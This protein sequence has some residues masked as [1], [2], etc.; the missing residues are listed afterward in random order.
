MGASGCLFNIVQKELT[1]K[2][3]EHCLLWDCT[4]LKIKVETKVMYLDNGIKK[5]FGASIK[6]IAFDGFWCNLGNQ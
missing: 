4:W 5:H 1:S 6:N 2:K 3:F